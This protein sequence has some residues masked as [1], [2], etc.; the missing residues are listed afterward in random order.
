MLPNK[1]FT[2][3]FYV[4]NIRSWKW[5]AFQYKMKALITAIQH[6][7]QNDTFS[8]RCLSLHLETNEKII[9]RY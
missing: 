8:A 3:D 4:F 2:N 1:R 7:V 5:F 9:Y 6:V